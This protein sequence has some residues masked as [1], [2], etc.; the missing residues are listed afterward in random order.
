MFKVVALSLLVSQAVLARDYIVKTKS[1]GF[2]TVQMKQSLGRID[3]LSVVDQNTIA[4][5]LKIKT[6]DANSVSVLEALRS[7]SDVEFVVPDLQIQLESETDVS[8]VAAAQWSLSQIH[9][10][11]AW[12]LAG[13]QGS[14]K[15]IVAVID[16]GVDY[17]HPSLKPNM[18]EGYD[19]TV[20]KP[21]GMDQTDHGTHCAGVIGSV[22]PDML[23]ISPTI[24]IMPLRFMNN[25]GGGS[26]YDAVRA[27]DYAIANHVDV[28][29]ASWGAELTTSEYEI[30][31]TEMVSR[32][33]KA[34][35]IFV[36]AVGN[37]SKDN[38]RIKYFP[39]NAPFPTMIAVGATDPSDQKIP[40]SNFGRTKVHVSAPGVD[41]LST[42]RAGGFKLMTGTSMATPLVAGLVALMKAQNP[43]LAPADY[44][45]ILEETGS[46]ADIENECKCRVDAE[47]A[48]RRAIELKASA[49]PS[50][51]AIKRQVTRFY[52]Q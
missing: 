8:I 45:K 28:I 37:R 26:L 18:V 36:A 42:I 22:G 24:S 47:R 1:N 35:V 43:N 11:Q 52:R 34:G 2:S 27:V 44:R 50:P 21:G 5:L 51:S 40:M 23:G 9:A 15:V 13:N 29:S 46:P 17:T 20:N 7:R 3:G 38:D 25:T 33:D 14:R 32:S 6:S 4:H 48:V 49:V 12:Q 16:S 41:I 39:S 31:L 30:L 10:S 19:F